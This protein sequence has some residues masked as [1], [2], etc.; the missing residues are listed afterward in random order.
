MTVVINSSMH[1][2]LLPSSNKGNH[3]FLS[4]PP[5]PIDIYIA[6]SPDKLAVS[7]IFFKGEEGI[8]CPSILGFTLIL[9]LIKYLNSEI[10]NYGM[11]H[12]N[13]LV[14]KNQPNEKGIY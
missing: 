13:V 10:N 4:T 11:L 6:T 12:S 9:N 2:S 5:P 1:F 7:T 8:K 14:R 3:K